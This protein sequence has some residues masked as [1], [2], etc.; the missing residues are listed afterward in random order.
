MPVI[1]SQSRCH[2]TEAD[3]AAASYSY[4]AHEQEMIGWKQS[5]DSSF[6]GTEN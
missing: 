3:D 6:Y 5:Q 2:G 4:L 1:E